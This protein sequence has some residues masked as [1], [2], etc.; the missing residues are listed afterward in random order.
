[1]KTAKIIQIVCWSL[2][3]VILIGVV[4][5][6]I[7]N[8]SEDS[9]HSLLWPEFSDWDD[10]RGNSGGDSR[11][12]GRRYSGDTY[13]VSAGG[14]K[15]ISV[16]WVSGNVDIVPYNGSDITFTETCGSPIDEDEK[17]VY[18]VKGDTLVIKY[19][20]NDPVFTFGRVFDSKSLTLKVPES[21][22]KKLGKLRVNAVS[23][24]IS[25][26]GLAAESA[27]IETV[28]G[29]IRLDGYEAG[30]MKFTTVSGRV[31]AEGKF[32]EVESESVSGSVKIYDSVCPE[33]VKIQTISGNA[34]LNIPENDGFRVEYDK[35]SGSFECDFPITTSKNSGTYKE[36]GASFEMETV[37]G[38]L[39]ITKRV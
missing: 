6:A 20:K 28:S 17:L 37:S 33:K 13:T 34:E 32:N 2:L 10:I 30:E 12:S 23:A 35:V 21:L 26:N 39:K 38:S 15:N 7:I 3:A 19:R 22:A 9:E 25:S 27:V 29:D 4:A 31:E 16:E 36:G 24:E 5:Y 11:G 8:R 18:E 14:V 1:M